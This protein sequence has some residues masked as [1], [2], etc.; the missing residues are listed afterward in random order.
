M[1]KQECEAVRQTFCILERLRDVA[2]NASAE[3]YDTDDMT[4]FSRLVGDVDM[5]TDAL[6]VLGRLLAREGAARWRD[7]KY[8]LTPTA[9]SGGGR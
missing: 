2:G 6:Y 8:E 1:T 5:Y 4:T 7:F 9:E 3:A